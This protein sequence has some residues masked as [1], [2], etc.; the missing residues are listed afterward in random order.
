MSWMN[1]NRYD[2]GNKVSVYNRINDDKFQHPVAEE[3]S[4]QNLLSYV[5]VNAEEEFWCS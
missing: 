5:S 3:L 1:R 2:W 4:N